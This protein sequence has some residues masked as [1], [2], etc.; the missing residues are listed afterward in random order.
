MKQFEQDLLTRLDRAHEIE[1]ETQRGPDKPIHRVIIWIVVDS[2]HAYVR[3]VRGPTGR[4]YRELRANPSGA[5][6]LGA[7]RIPIRAVSVDDPAT[8][9]Q[10]D[11]AFQRKYRTSRALPMILREET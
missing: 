11:A 4:W 8:I 5:L 7:E 9:A 2:G 6:H 3:S 10:V 1:I